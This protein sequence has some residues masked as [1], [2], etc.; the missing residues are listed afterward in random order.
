MLMLMTPWSWAPA[1]E[2]IQAHTSSR[3]ASAPGWAGAEEVVVDIPATRATLQISSIK[4]K[5]LVMVEVLCFLQRK[6]LN[7]RYVMIRRLYLWLGTGAIS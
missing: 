6:T 7:D 5:V 4:G 2:D 1:T 3:L